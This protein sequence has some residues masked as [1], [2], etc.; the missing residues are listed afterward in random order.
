[1]IKVFAPCPEST[2]LKTLPGVGEILGGDWDPDRISSASVAL[3]N[4]PATAAG[5]RAT[6]SGGKFRYGPV[7][8][9]VN[10]YLKWAFVEAANSSVLNCQRCG[11]ELSTALP[12]D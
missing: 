12:T 6:S 5:W 3:S 1:M 9:D 7:R 8:R 11:Y 10:V 4:S 2:L